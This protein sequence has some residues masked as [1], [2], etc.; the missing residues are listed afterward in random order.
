VGE[1]PQKGFWSAVRKGGAVGFGLES[2]AEKADRW[3]R[4]DGEKK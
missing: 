2:P 4:G 3:K 1:S